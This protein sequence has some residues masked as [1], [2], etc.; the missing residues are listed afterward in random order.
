MQTKTITRQAALIAFFAVAALTAGCNTTA[1]AGKD[2]QAAG[3]KIQNSADEHK[4]Y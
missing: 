2:I 3:S 4:N 1:G